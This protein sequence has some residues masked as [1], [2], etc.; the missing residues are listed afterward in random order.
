MVADRRRLRS[1]ERTPAAVRRRRCCEGR[2][3]RCGA[4]GSSAHV[5]TTPPALAQ[6]RLELLGRLHRLYCG[7]HSAEAGS[8]TPREC[9]ERS[10]GMKTPA[11]NPSGEID[12]QGLTPVMKNQVWTMIFMVA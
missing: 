12:R 11:E 6:K 5:N 3:P 1:R 2:A 9:D 10:P 8:A 7:G 4:T